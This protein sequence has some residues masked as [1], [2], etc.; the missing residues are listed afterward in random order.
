MG[1]VFKTRLFAEG[2][3]RGEKTNIALSTAGG[4]IGN[5]LMGAGMGY[6]GGRLVGKLATPDKETFV[7]RYLHSH[8]NAT[9]FEAEE[10]YRKRR[11]KF[12]KYGAIAGGALGAINGAVAG[13]LVGKAG[14]E[15][16]RGIRSE[17]QRSNNSHK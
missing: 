4:A 6:L 8:P 2:Y 11:G 3:T 14:V 12:K 5:G 10:A 1:L 13:N 9:K 16:N 7:E 15:L 17:I